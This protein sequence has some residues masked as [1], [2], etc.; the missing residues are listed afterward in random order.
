[1]GNLKLVKDIV[2]SKNKEKL[3]LIAIKKYGKE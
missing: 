1:M 2:T 3:K